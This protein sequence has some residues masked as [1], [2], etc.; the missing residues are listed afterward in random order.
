MTRLFIP[1]LELFHHN[2]RAFLTHETP[3]APTPSYLMIRD[4]AACPAPD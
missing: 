4:L 1:D 3:S 2:I